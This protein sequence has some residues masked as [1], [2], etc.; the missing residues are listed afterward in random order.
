[1]KITKDQALKLTEEKIVQFE[2]VLEK[3][4]YEN[5]YGESYGLAYHGAET[6]VTE[7]FSKE[8]AM[9]FRRNV[10]FPMVSVGGEVDYEAELEDYKKHLNWCI[11]QLKVYHER[12]SNFWSD[13]KIEKLTDAKGSRQM[14]TGAFS[15]KNMAPPDPRKI[16]VAYG[17][18]EE[19]RGSLFAF[20]RAIGLHPLEWIELI[21]S[22]GEGSPYIGK[23]LQKGFAEAK[24]V[25]ILMS[26][27]DIG[28]IRKQFRVKEDPPSETE[29][30]P[31][32]RLNVIF[33]AGM[34]F[35][36]CAE[37]T[38]IVELG[39]LRPFSD[40]S[41]RHVVRLDNSAEKRQELA[42]RLLTLGCATDLTG[43]D[44][45]SAGNFEIK[46]SDEEDFQGLMV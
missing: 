1:M 12:I 13:E 20:L 15:Q 44:W 31:Q 10:T 23:I 2:N 30:T 14:E 28:K 25:I 32:A 42:Q 34:A 6:L 9:T 3:A 16:L 19:A 11:T 33:E 43:K 29:L 18:N 22:T 17:R 38:I 40:I 37:R 27:D 24:A 7:L 45:L 35:G 5:R 36:F 41:G 39:S 46:T 8:E 4:T 21:K 26:P